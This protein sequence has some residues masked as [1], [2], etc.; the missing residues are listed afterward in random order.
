M[1]LLINAP[2]RLYNVSWVESSEAGATAH[3]S[4]FSG[5]WLMKYDL[6]WTPQPDG[7]FPFLAKDYIWSDGTG[8]FEEHDGGVFVNK[9]VTMPITVSSDNY[10]SVIFLSAWEAD[11][12]GDSQTGFCG[13]SICELWANMPLAILTQ[14][15]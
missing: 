3:S 10:Y 8:W 13:Q 7:F 14:I 2:I 4:G 15:P 5:V 11:G 12:S 9:P 1:L 6:D